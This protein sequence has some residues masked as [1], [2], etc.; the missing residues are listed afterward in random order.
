MRLWQSLL[1]CLLR[2][3]LG[4]GLMW[5]AVSQAAPHINWG[6]MLAQTQGQLTRESLEVDL[7]QRWE[8]TFVGGVEVDN[9]M[10]LD[11]D[12]VWRWP[13]ERFSSRPD[14]ATRSLMKGERKVARLTVFSESLNTDFNLTVMMPRVDAVHVSY[15]HDGGVWK[16]LSAGDRL[17]MNRW[18]LVDRQPS[19]AYLCRPDKLIW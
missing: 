5:Q 17:A 1:H 8:S 9:E 3:M 15:R 2:S 16:T 18:P 4:L 13:A 10:A 19:L 11:P 12:Q 14:V 7:R 6:E